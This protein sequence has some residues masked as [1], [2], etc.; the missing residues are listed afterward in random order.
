MVSVAVSLVV[1]GVFITFVYW[2]RKQKVGDTFDVSEGSRL[3]TDQAKDLYRR[4]PSPLITLEYS[5]RW[6]PMTPEKT[7][8]SFCNEFLQELKFN[9]EEVDSA[10]QHFSESNLLGKSNFSAVYKGILKD[11]SAVAIKSINVTACKS[12]EDEFMKGLNLI[13]SLKHD[14]LANL[15]GF[16]CSKGR[17]ECILI[18]DFA[19]KGNL[20]QYLDVEE[21][22][23]HILNWPTR[24]SIIKGIAEGEFT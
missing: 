3:S 10:T 5:E 13:T 9:M 11:G 7:F 2:R 15:R 1:A 17:G 18:Y 16:C 8:G 22:S 6:D 23:S 20:S 21:G 19:S 4:S 24:V 14:N 12:D